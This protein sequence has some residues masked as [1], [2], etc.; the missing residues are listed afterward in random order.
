MPPS[1]PNKLFNISDL[2]YVQHKKVYNEEEF[3]ERLQIF[4]EN[5]RR[6]DKHNAGNHSFSS[7][8]D[9]LLHSAL[10][11]ARLKY[12]VT[13]FTSLTVR[14]NQFSDM[15]FGE[16]RKNFLWTERQVISATGE[17]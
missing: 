5:K 4:I 6:I 10:F 3:S 16:F 2:F 12:V 7:K 15:T 8:N 14:L 13:L 17:V 1:I 11:P 9:F